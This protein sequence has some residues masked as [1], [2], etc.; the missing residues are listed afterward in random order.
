MCTA[1]PGTGEDIHAAEAGPWEVLS[2][3]PCQEECVRPQRKSLS[4]CK[5][6]LVSST[7]KTYKYGRWLR[8]NS[9]Y[10][11]SW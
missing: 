1:V 4:F 11:Q 3:A 5:V 6:F 10:L 8:K 2:T 9:A 7:D